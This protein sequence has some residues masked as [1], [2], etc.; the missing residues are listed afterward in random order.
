M[1]DDDGAGAQAGHETF[2]ALQAVEVEVV[3]RLVE[4][5]D[6][7][8]ERGDEW[9]ASRARAARPPDR[10]AI[11]WCRSTVRPSASAVS[12]VPVVEVGA[13]QGSSALQAGRVGVVGA[14]SGR[15]P[16]PGWPRPCSALR[17]GICRCGRARNARIVRRA[18]A[19]AS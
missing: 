7:V 9:E 13:A 12:A 18:A 11:G 1:A 10:D 16:V 19:R 2:E 6:V 4:Q 17:L 14:G 15:R 5:E 8:A 3:G